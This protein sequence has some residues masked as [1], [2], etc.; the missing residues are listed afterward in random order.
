MATAPQ[1]GP[2]GRFHVDVYWEFP[3]SWLLITVPVELLLG[4]AYALV[5]VAAGGG[6]LPCFLAGHPTG[7]TEESGASVAAVVIGAV[8]WLVGAV[9]AA[10]CP[11]RQGQ[12]LAAWLVANIVAIIVFCLAVAPAIWGSFSC[13]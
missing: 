4:I 7:W 8:L 5:R 6:V 2:R 13:E 10:V 12:V 1:H 3:G 9:A 11:N